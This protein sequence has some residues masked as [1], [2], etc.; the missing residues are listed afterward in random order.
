MGLTQRGNSRGR[1]EAGELE[2][3]EKPNGTKRWEETGWRAV[4]GK[5]WEEVEA[6]LRCQRVAKSRGIFL[7]GLEQSRIL[8]PLHF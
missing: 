3:L 6:L 8:D 2:G 5:S 7:K 4:Q 1:P